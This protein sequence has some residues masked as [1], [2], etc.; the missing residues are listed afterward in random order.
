MGSGLRGLVSR[1][2]C[3]AFRAGNVGPCCRGTPNRH[4]RRRLQLPELFISSAACDS[5]RTLLHPHWRVREFRT[6]R[7][8]LL[9][10]S[11]SSINGSH[12][13]VCA[14]AGFPDLPSR[15]ESRNVRIA[16]LLRTCSVPVNKAGAAFSC[17][18]GPTQVQHDS[19]GGNRAAPLH[20]PSPES[21]PEANALYHPHDAYYKAVFEAP[22]GDQIALP[23]VSGAGFAIPARFWAH[24]ARTAGAR[25]ASRFGPR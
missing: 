14:T 4:W 21:M 17:S 13:Y 18:T 11:V 15:P 22:I 20:P 5:M 16:R 12:A 9:G 1:Y 25:R 6:T 23:A 3:A 8:S 2:S 10:P 19:P 7:P 24:F